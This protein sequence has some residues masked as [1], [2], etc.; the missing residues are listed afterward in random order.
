METFHV[1]FCNSLEFPSQR[2]Q[3]DKGTCV[4]RQYSNGTA[5]SAQWHNYVSRLLVWQ[6]HSNQRP[7]A[8]L[9]Q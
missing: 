9:C 6:R 1:H 7:M 8:Q 4:S 3:T 2:L 5:I